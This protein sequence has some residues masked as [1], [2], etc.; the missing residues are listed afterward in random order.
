MENAIEV[1][2][3]LFWVNLVFCQFE[4]R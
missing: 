4:S 1:E 2:N 3:S